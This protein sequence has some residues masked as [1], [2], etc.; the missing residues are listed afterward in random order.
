VRVKIS[1]MAS[2]A[3]SGKATT[4]H[5]FREQAL[6]QQVEPMKSAK[7]DAKHCSLPFSPLCI[8]NAA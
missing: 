8:R 1:L 3:T 2:V 7:Y 4:L 6:K 5:R